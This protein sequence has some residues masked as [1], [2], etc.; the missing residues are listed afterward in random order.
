MIR[1]A[2]SGDI[3]ELVRIENACFET[4]RLSPRQFRYLI[5]QAKAATLVA[6]DRHD[7]PLGYV[8]I[9]FHRGTSLA[10]LYSIA[11]DP[12]RRGAGLGTALLRAAEAAALEEGVTHMRLEVRVDDL[13]TQ[14]LYE[15]EGYRRLGLRSHYYEDET[16]AVRMEKM[17][18]PPREAALARVPYYPQSLSFTCGPAALL[19]AMHALRP[20]V[21]VDQAAELKLWREATTIFMTSG[22]GGCAPRGLALA[23]WRRGF[24]VDLYLSQ[25][26][27]FFINSVRSPEKRAVI[28][29]VE[30]EFQDELEAT[31]VRV[32]D[33]PLAINEM[34]E[35]F[36]AG[37]IPV[38]LI[39]SYRFDRSKEPHW[40]VVTGFDQGYI[41]LHDPFIDSDAH[42][43]QTD[44]MQI[45]VP[46]REFARMARY[47]RSQQKAA[48][49]L[50]RRAS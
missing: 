50:R 2:R 30:E 12:P 26:S 19:M 14:G 44:C 45:P 49:V 3:D 9:L 41:Y 34:R 8:T 48:L 16:D 18:V 24:D 27:S 7:R 15:R 40:V 10:R 25:Q 20:E 17:L 42:K 38:V 33:R 1:S 46:L 4:D 23:A 21:T 29:L 5:Q 37:G 31:D 22:H 13:K 32:H 39:S 47:G 28:R 35:A 36:E 43:N 6:A 11:V